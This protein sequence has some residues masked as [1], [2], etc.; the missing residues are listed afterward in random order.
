MEYLLLLVPFGAWNICFDVSS[1]V[2][3]D[4]SLSIMIPDACSFWSMEY[5]L[6]S[7]TV[8]LQIS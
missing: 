7:A 6:L 5:L 4:F 8:P 1:P 2:Y 3:L